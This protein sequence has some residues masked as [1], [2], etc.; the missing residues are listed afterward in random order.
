MPPGL[1]SRSIVVVMMTPPDGV[2][3]AY[4]SI[5]LC[6]ED[7]A[8]G[9]NEMSRGVDVEDWAAPGVSAL[10]E[11]WPFPVPL[12]C[13]LPS[14]AFAPQL[15]EEALEVPA[16]SLDV[17]HWMTAA[18]KRTV[19]VLVMMMV[20]EN[21]ENLLSQLQLI[22]HTHPGSPSSDIKT[23]RLLSKLASTGSS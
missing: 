9:T 18:E 5:S 12:P 10:V 11:S 6:V 3:S 16:L 17:T 14:L 4:L 2:L 13:P 15:V 22:K 23:E 19:G 20:E 8:V 7:R 1:V 21:W